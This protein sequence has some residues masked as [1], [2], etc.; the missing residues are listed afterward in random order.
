MSGVKGA[1]RQFTFGSGKTTDRNSSRHITSF[2]RGSGAKRL[3]PTVDLK[4]NT[5]SSLGV[6]STVTGA[7]TYLSKLLALNPL[8]LTVTTFVVCPRSI[9]YCCALELPLERF[10]CLHT[11]SELESVSS[12]GLSRVAVTASRAPF[13]APRGKREETLVQGDSPNS[14]T[15]EKKKLEDA[16]SSLNEKLVEKENLL[17]NFEG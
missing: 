14:M 7:T 6:V 16:S 13:F 4:R 5:T 10:F 12:I 11:K 15:D 8:S 9:R 1:L 2:H 17:E 3:Q